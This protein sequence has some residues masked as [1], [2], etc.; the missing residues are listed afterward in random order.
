MGAI[1]NVSRKKK[2]ENNQK[3]IF[4]LRGTATLVHTQMH[5]QSP[6]G[7]RCSKEELNFFHPI[8]W[9]VGLFFS[10]S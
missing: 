2:K 1:E 8:R 3:T 4:F 6:I 7:V 10:K 9:T 5:T